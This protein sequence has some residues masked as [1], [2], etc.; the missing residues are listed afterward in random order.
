MAAYPVLAVLF[1]SFY[2]VVCALTTVFW[3]GAVSGRHTESA[4]ESSVS[5]EA[6]QMRDDSYKILLLNS[7]FV[8]SIM[9]TVFK[10]R[11]S[12]GARK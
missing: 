8:K 7:F 4:P 6:R 5:D 2:W 10:N 3:A 12:E 11:I 9:Q 1:P